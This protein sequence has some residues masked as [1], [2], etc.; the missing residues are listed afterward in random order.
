MQRLQAGQILVR[1][2]L[3]WL[4]GDQTDAFKALEHPAQRWNIQRSVGRSVG[5][6]S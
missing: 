2:A 6:L 4:E 5:C 1:V 3:G